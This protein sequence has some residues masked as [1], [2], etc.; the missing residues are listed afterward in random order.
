MGRHRIS[1]FIKIARRRTTAGWLFFVLVA[2]FSHGGRWPAFAG[3]LL[4]LAGELFRTFSAGIIKKDSV[5]AT[6]GPYR[7]CRNPLYFGSFLLG[8]GLCVMANHIIVWLYFSIFFPVFYIAAIMKEQRFLEKEF[9]HAYR[10]Y[11]KNVPAFFPLFRKTDLRDFSWSRVIE[12]KEYV[13]WIAAGIL[14][15]LHILKKWVV[16]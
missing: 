14:F 12:N 1:P 11:V 6:N 7:L 16:F 3:L 2:V 10:M 13:N 9:G 5:L 15:V 8:F 4:V